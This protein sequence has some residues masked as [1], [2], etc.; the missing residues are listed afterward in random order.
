MP[1]GIPLFGGA[2]ISTFPHVHGMRGHHEYRT[3][4]LHFLDAI[5]GNSMFKMKHLLK[6]FSMFLLTFA[7]VA[8]GGGGDDDS[9]PAATPTS[10]TGTL[11]DVSN[12]EKNAQLVG[13]WRYTEV[14]GSGGINLVTDYFMQFKANGEYREWV[15]QSAGSG[16]LQAPPGNASL[17]YWFTGGNQVTFISPTTKGSGTYTFGFTDGGRYVMLTP[18]NGRVFER[19]R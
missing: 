14:F 9:D 16:G 4:R 8:C 6:L 5:S 13:T 3:M 1:V 10:F 18:D 12:K 15:G 7:L 19:I 17:Y 11:A 2:V